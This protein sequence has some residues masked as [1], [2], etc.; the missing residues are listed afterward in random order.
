MPIA[1]REVDGDDEDEEDAG[2]IAKVGAKTA[3]AGLLLPLAA[4]AAIL[5]KD[6]EKEAL[7]VVRTT[8]RRITPS[9]C[10]LW[11][12]NIFLQVHLV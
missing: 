8:A 2:E 9:S 6:R 12:R 11:Y 3:G 7:I 1:R 4:R 10:C 5:V